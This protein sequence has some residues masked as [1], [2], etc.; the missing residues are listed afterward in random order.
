MSEPIR[1]TFPERT[2]VEIQDSKPIQ[3]VKEHEILVY[4][5]EKPK[6]LEAVASACL[7]ILQCEYAHT[8]STSVEL[9][10]RLL[11]EALKGEK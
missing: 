3:V 6:D 11:R 7:I 1:L 5:D 4:T 8:G 2:T 10:I 9:C